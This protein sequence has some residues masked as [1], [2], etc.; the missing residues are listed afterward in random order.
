MARPFFW[1]IVVWSIIC[2][3]G[4]AV[5][6]L[7]A[8]MPIIPETAEGQPSMG[9]SVAFWIIAWIV[10]TLMLAYSGRRK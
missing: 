4:L 5:Y 6:L 7:Q 1:L 2:A 8:Y 10:P 9:V 3:S